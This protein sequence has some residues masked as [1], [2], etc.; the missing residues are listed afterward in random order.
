VLENSQL[1]S[2]ELSQDMAT[3]KEELDRAVPFHELL[4]VSVSK[5]KAEL[6]HKGTLLATRQR[7]STEALRAT[8]LRKS[9]STVSSTSDSGLPVSPH[10]NQ[11]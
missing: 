7:P 2:Q 6:V 8:V 10:A 11:L 1:V 3:A 4:D 5:S 9:V